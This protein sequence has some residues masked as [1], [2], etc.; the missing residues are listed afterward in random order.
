MSNDTVKIYVC[1]RDTIN[2]IMEMAGA[3]SHADAQHIYDVL[4]GN[5]PV[6]LSGYPD[7]FRPCHNIYADIYMLDKM[8]Y[9]FDFIDVSE[10][11]YWDTLADR[12][13]LPADAVSYRHQA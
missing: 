10:R 11:E 2:N 7:T 3:C 12:Y 1:G 8:S 13:E 6:S 5:A 9:N 4:D